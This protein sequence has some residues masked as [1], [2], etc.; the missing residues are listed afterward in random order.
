MNKRRDFIKK[1]VALAAAGTISPN[2]F[3]KPFHISNKTADNLA[4]DAGIQ[5]SLAYFWGIEPA[6]VALSKQ[7][8]VYGAVGGIS[9]DMV[10]MRGA[11]NY[12]LPVIKAVKN[13][14]KDVGLDLKVIEGP[15]SLNIKTKLGLAGRDEEIENFIT[16]IKN[17]GSVGIDTVCH[18]WMPVISWARTN[19][20]K[21]NRGGALVSS[22]DIEDI[23]EEPMI[24][25]Y[26]EL[27]HQKMWDNMEYFLKAVIPEAEKA[28]VKLALHPDDP[29][30]DFI[31]GIPRIMTSVAAF[32]KMLHLY[33]S[34]SNGITFCQGSFASMGN[35]GVGEDI[36]AA[37]RYFGK[38]NAIHFVHFRDVKGSKKKFEEAFHDDGKTDMYAAMKAYYD[39]G[40]KGPLRPDHVPTMYG[41]SNEN[42]GY[43][44]IGT[45]FAIGYIRGLIEGVSKA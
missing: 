19:I 22:F 37:I 28:G 4:K 6:K 1:S 35:E 24:T 7:M 38:R 8:A 36:P 30:I 21:A 45:L 23:K 42:A 10:N 29:P 17:L 15:P 18:N 9:P 40:F 20:A 11:A 14:W 41:D 43:S 27:T 12:S 32:K 3:S 25:E 26:G 16:F 13:A 44:T 34:P 33:P 5:L 2:A 39:I 31:R